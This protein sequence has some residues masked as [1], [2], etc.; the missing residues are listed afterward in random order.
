MTVISLGYIGWMINL[1]LH[2]LQSYTS[3]PGNL[4]SRKEEAAYQRN[5]TRKVIS[6]CVSCI[7]YYYYYEEEDSINKE[8][9]KSLEILCKYLNFLALSVIVI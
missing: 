8:D 6:V 2:V 5:D 4:F 3:L 9:S 7:C 1:V